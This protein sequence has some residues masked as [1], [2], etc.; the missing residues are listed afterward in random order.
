MHPVQLHL[1]YCGCNLRQFLLKTNVFGFGFKTSLDLVEMPPLGLSQYHR[2]N[3]GI[4]CVTE[5]SDR[6]E[7]ITDTYQAVSQLPQPNRDTMAYLIL[8]LQRS[9]STVRPVLTGC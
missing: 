9:V 3:V 2:H 4:A 8:H 5:K 6:F 7:S 1:L